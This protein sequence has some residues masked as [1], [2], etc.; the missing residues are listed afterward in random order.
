MALHRWFPPNFP[1]SPPRLREA[2]RSIACPLYSAPSLQR[3]RQHSWNG[4][5]SLAWLLGLSFTCSPAA[6]AGDR[7]LKPLSLN[8]G[9]IPTL[10][11]Y[12]PTGTSSPNGSSVGTN[13]TRAYEPTN[14]SSPS[15][16]GGN[17]TRG[18]CNSSTGNTLTLLA[19]LGHIGRTV[20]TRP[21]LVWFISDAKPY[22]IELSLFEYDS[23][24]KGKRLLS[25]NLQSTRGLMQWSLPVDQPELSVGKRYLWQVAVLCD[26]NRP[27]KDQIAEAVVEV[28]ASPTGLNAELSAARSPLKQAEVYAK[29]GIWYDALSATLTDIKAKAFQQT[30]LDDLIQLESEKDSDTSRQQT[31]QLREVI[32]VQKQP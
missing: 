21:T 3:H 14:P 27:S 28:V 18:S 17:T 29:A 4:Y 23:N 30:L 20:S 5:K 8:Q 15:R 10:A 31:R 32:A 26:R 9:E 25:A 19:P 16:T 13:S 11:A 22:P 24:G 6:F 12:E 7:S 2:A 1:Q